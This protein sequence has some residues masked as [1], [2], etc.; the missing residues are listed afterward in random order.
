MRYNVE[1]QLD[2]IDMPRFRKKYQDRDKFM[3]F[4]RECPRYDSLWSCP[5]LSFD[6]DKFLE[7]YV[8]INLLCAKIHLDDE[9][10]RAADTA[11][12]IKAMGWDIVSVVKLDTDDRLRKLEAQV[13][14]SLSLSSGG[15]NLCKNCT[16]KSGSPC[17]QP[18]KMRYSLDA[19][20]FD[21]TAI[22]K[23][24]FHID[25]LW[26]KDSLP[27]YFTLIHGLLADKPVSEELWRTVGLHSAI[28]LT[29]KT[30]RR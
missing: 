15:C 13:P 7:P 19:F 30:T 20:G 5:S 1:Y 26:C 18:D 22:T 16:R 6:V 10:I 27:K 24:V 2:H 23:D 14:E 8:W 3:A 17:R 21:L 11:D 29:S 4:C 12:K 9:T 28:A 25:I